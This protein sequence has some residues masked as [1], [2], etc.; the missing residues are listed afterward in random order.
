MITFPNVR[1]DALDETHVAFGQVLEDG[2]CSPA[3][4]QLGD[5]R[6][7]DTFQRVTIEQCGVLK[8]IFWGCA[9]DGGDGGR[10]RT[11]RASGPDGG[12][13]APAAATPRLLH[14][15]SCSSVES[16]AHP[17]RIPAPRG[18][19]DRVENVRM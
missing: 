2:P 19:D 7:E 9:D 3:L 11:R 1:P 16:G 6:Q 4:E 18:V 14:A 12:R 8:K 5:A 17:R 13:G 10:E 15:P